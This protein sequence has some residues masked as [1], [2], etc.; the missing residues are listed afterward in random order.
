[1]VKADAGV[2]IGPQIKVM[3]CKE[4]PKNL[5]RMEKA[6]WNSFV[7]VVLGFLEDHKPKNYMEL[8]EILMRNYSKMGCSR[9]SLKIHILDTRLDELKRTCGHTPRS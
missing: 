8:V 7:T 4:F 9:M 6:G 1:M 3:E 2:F 5:T